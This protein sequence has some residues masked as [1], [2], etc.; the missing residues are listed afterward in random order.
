MS[1]TVLEPTLSFGD[2]FD[3]PFFHGGESSA[4]VGVGPAFHVAIGGHEYV[5]DVTKYRRTTMQIRRLQTDDSVEPGENSL[6]A[7]G[8]WPRAQDNFF[9]GAGQLF[10]DNRFA[11]ETVY[12]HS[13]ES[14]SVRTRYW[15]S[16]GLNPW[17]E[18]QI[19]MQPEQHAIRSSSNTNLDSVATADA[20]FIA[21]GNDVFYS[22]NPTAS[23]PTWTSTGIGTALGAHAITG[24]ATDGHRVWACSAGGLAYTDD[25][26]GSATKLGTSVPLN[27]WYAK[28]FLICTTTGRDLQTIDASGTLTSVYTHPSLTFVWNTVTDTPSCI[29]VAGNTGP[30]SFIGA[31][32]ADAATEGATL[33]VPIT[34]TTLPAGETIN[35]IDYSSGFVLL[36]TSLGIRS[37]TRPD[38][39]GIFDVNPV[40]TD[41]GPCYSV[42]AWMRFCYFGMQNYNPN[43]GLISGQPSTYSGLGRADLSQYTDAGIPAYASDVLTAGVN[44]Q[45][46]SISILN[47]M[48]Y[49]TLQGN[50]MYGSDGNVVQNAFL[51]TG[52]IRYGTL[53]SKILTSILVQHL[54][55]LAGQGVTVQVADQNNNVTA[56]GV[57]NVTGATQGGPYGGNLQVGQRFMVILTLNRGTDTTQGPTLHNW[58]SKALIT[59][60]RQDEIICPILLRSKVEEANVDGYPASFDTLAEFLYLKAIEATGTPILYQELDHNDQAYIDQVQ[61]APESV[62]RSLEGGDIWWNCTC[63]VKLITLTSTGI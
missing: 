9:L 58:L 25:T 43:D 2:P 20:V 61:I 22:T 35:D 39:T 48:P 51:E 26:A 21:D 8:N 40:I 49:Y 3:T 33:A 56:L 19:T 11:F 36:G 1:P 34:A 31:L 18:G 46:S 16:I 52:W 23:T 42:A 29:L 37:G 59:P 6:N 10:M 30:V 57:D 12:V 47:G 5:V 27:L 38:S 28:G 45:V 55:L 63:T 24:I 54:P 13:G 50:G 7:T 53:E 4:A 62:N 32:Q 17:S 15:R 60:A 41:F 14:P 44:A